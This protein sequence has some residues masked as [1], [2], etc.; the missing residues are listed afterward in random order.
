MTGESTG[1]GVFERDDLR[2]VVLVNA[3][4]RFSL[5]PEHL[6]VPG[7]WSVAFGTASR[8]ACLDYV[9]TAWTDFVTRSPRGGHPP[10]AAVSSTALGG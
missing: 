10:N 8:P 2:Y 3:K 4:S 7:G 9:E 1:T 6:M 5:W